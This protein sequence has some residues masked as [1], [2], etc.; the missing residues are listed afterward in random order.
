MGNSIITCFKLE[1]PSKNG[2]T[3][4]DGNARY[5]RSTTPARNGS[6]SE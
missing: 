6:A 5:G 1:K 3:K 4:T 2:L